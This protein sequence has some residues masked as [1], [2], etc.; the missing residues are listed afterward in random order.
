MPDATFDIITELFP[1]LS[2]EES[3]ELLSSLKRLSF[4]AHVTICNE[5]EVEDGF[6]IIVSGSV[7]IFKVL[8]GQ[9]LLINHLVEGAHFGDISLLLDLPRT[10]TI[11]TAEPTELLMIDRALFGVFVE[12]NAKIVVALSRFVIRRFLLQEEKQLT[13][14]ARFKK[15]ATVPATVF[16]SYARVDEAF[17]VRLAN[18]L[19]KYDIDVWLDLYRIE[20]GKSW[21]RQIGEA[22]DDCQIMLLVLS[23]DACASENVDDEWNYF[24]DLKKKIVS[25]LHQPC[26]VPYRLSKLHYVDFHT[27]G[28]DLAM[29]RL[30]AT[31]N[32]I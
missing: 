9:R 11:I 28:F 27:T 1:T 10:A 14:I 19:L 20:P 13:E 24:L 25:V 21:A 8:E 32:T 31:L 22:L 29:A 7:D 6:Y 26:K 3:D 16:V 4:P 23:P 15:P 30:V 5:G 12:K 17:V 18:N 2:G